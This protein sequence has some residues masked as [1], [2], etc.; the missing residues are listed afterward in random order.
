[1]KESRFPPPHFLSETAMAWA[2]VCEWEVSSLKP[3]SVQMCFAVTPHLTMHP[4]PGNEILPAPASSEGLC[5]GPQFHHMLKISSGALLFKQHSDLELWVHC[6]DAVVQC[7]Q[8]PYHCIL[9]LAWI[10]MSRVA[11]FIMYKTKMVTNFLKTTHTGTLE[12]KKNL[13]YA[14]IAIPYEKDESSHLSAECF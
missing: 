8:Q 12:K 1:M 7:S 9:V 14:G 4:W 10:S 2:S 6:A 5:W 3:D 11:E 13:L